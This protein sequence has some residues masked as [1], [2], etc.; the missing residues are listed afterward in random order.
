MAQPVVGVIRKVAGTRFTLHLKS[1]EDLEVDETEAEGAGMSEVLEVGRA[2]AV[3][4]TKDAKGLLHAR[5][6]NRSSLFKATH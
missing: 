1:G 2:V 3:I 6:I 5:V 4:G